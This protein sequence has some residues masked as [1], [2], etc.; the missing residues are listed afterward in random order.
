MRRIRLVCEYDGTSYCGWQIQP[1]GISVQEVIERELSALVNEDVRVHGSGRTDAGV[2]ARAQVL[3]FDTNSRIPA[4]KFPYALNVS[5]P[6][7]IRVIYGDETDDSFHARFGVEKKHYRYTLY[8]A[9]HASAFYRNT[10]LHVHH[11]LDTDAMSEA[12]R[13]LLGEHDFIAFKSQGVDLKSTIRT[14][15]RSEWTREGRFLHYDIAGSGFMY[16]MV[17]ILVGTML[18]IGKGYIGAETIEKALLSGQRDDAGA[19][20]PAHGLTMMRV[21]YKNFDTDWI[22][23]GK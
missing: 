8:L 23:N 15:Y 18:E 13:S 19:T 9:P 21:E 6:P 14:I 22:F 16:N 7:D 10:S 17:R 4:E 12:A 3:H 11:T 1:N 20:A 5:L 2:H